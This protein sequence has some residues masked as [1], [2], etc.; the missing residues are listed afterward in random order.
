MIAENIMIYLLN[1]LKSFK[2]IIRI[3]AYIP[4]NRIKLVILGFKPLNMAT[5][6]TYIKMIRNIFV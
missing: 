3:D 2:A 6:T 1:I 5:I 4:N